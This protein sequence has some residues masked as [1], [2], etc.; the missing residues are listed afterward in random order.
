MSTF[1]RPAFALAVLALA[2]VPGEHGLPLE[3]QEAE[4]FLK[5]ADVVKTE[6][7]RDG[8]TRSDRVT[9]TDGTR[10]LKAIWKTIDKVYPATS[11][12]KGRGFEAMFKDSYK[13]EIAAY[14]LDKLLGLELVPPTV[15]RTIKNKTGSLQLWVEGAFTE[16]ERQKRKLRPK[17][18]WRY[19]SQM[20][21]VY[22]WN[23]LTNNID[24]ANVT[25]VLFDPDFRVYAVDHSRCFRV[26]HDLLDESTLTR[27]SRSVLARLRELNRDLLEEKLGQWLTSREIEALL[28]RRERILTLVDELVAEMGEAAV[29]YP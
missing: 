2:P 27:F 6:P 18:P 4:H 12:L 22:L 15:E 13:Y 23:Q 21:K 25:N 9:L 3:G 24:A 11:T 19:G 29:V 16:R 20:Y 8:V 5:N 10:T 7:I 14:E 26:Q 1:S 28:K 17:D